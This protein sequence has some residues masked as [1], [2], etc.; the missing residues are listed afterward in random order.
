[1]VVDAVVRHWESLVEERVG[2]G[3]SSDGNNV[4]AQ[5]E[6]RTI[7]ERDDSRRQA[8][9]EHESLTV[10]SDFFY[11]DNRLVASTYPG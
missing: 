8:E 11:E 9:E 1:M 2:G 10:K 6:G 3:D 7:Q 4:T 5:M